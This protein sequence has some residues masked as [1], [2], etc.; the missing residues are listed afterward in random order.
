MR[1]LVF[2]LMTLFTITV[3]YSDIPD[4][5]KLWDKYDADA[6]D[7]K[8]EENTSK[9][10]RAAEYVEKRKYSD[11]LRLYEEMLYRNLGSSHLHT[12]IGFC[13][14]KM[15]DIENAMM[16]Y[17]KATSLTPVDPNAY[18][19]LAY[20]TARHAAGPEEAFSALRVIDKALKYRKDDISFL[21]TRLFVLEKAG[22]T[23]EWET[24]LKGLIGKY[25]GIREFSYK[26]GKFYFDKDIID[27]ALKYLN[28]AIPHEKAYELL[29]EIPEYQADD[30]EPERFATA[31]ADDTTIDERAPSDPV[32][33]SNIKK[34]ENDYK[35]NI[36]SGEDK[37]VSNT[38]KSADDIDL[39]EVD[40]S[41]DSG[42]VSMERVVLDGAF[43]KGM[44]NYNKGREDNA[45]EYFDKVIK[46]R[47]KSKDFSQELL[48]SAKYRSIILTKKGRMEPS[49][50]ED[51]DFY[52]ECVTTETFR[53]YRVNGNMKMARD[54]LLLILRM[55]SM[56]NMRD[57]ASY[58]LSVMDGHRNQKE[59]LTSFLDPEFYLPVRT[60]VT[61]RGETVD[62]LSKGYRNIMEKKITSA[63]KYFTLSV[64]NEITYYPG[65]YNLAV[66][67]AK[68]GDIAQAYTHIENAERYC[69]YQDELYRRIRRLY[70]AL[71]IYAG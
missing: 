8:T 15:G 66:L 12:A 43:E 9:L 55:E 44:E 47:L 5:K 2:F 35:I 60:E 49:E 39:P 54:T 19:N 24:Y 20:L 56:K 33:I 16:L 25:P 27:K 34:F 50:W 30:T 42:R 22:M 6:E 40:I 41:E 7:T 4:I 17:T 65:H 57:L 26:L 14:E 23:E 69:P 36:T 67:S 37:K 29:K 11:A 62:F 53:K 61:F 1:R 31:E 70:N 58:R 48:K 71:V 52:E 28:K 46:D 3:L 59:E 45:L 38:K 13:F 63:E 64:R 10:E 32:L 51:I 68:N 18:N 21:K